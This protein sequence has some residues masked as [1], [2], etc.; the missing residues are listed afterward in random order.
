M[1]NKLVLLNGPDAGPRPD[2]QR[3]AVCLDAIQSGYSI[4]ADHGWRCN[5]LGLHLHQ[6]VGATR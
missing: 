6:Q 3:A 5:A 2:A 4:N 1:L